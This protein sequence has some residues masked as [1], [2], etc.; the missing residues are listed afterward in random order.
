VKRSLAGFPRLKFAV[1]GCVV[2]GR[3]VLGV[4]Y[5]GFVGAGRGM[6]TLYRGRE[7]ARRNVPEEVAVEVLRQ[8][9]I[10]EMEV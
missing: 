1:L 3:G 9:I 6:V 8:L 5:Y 2:N 4:A 10:D 7:V